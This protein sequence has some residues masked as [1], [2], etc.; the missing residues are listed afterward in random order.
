MAIKI[1]ELRNKQGPLTEE[2]RAAAYQQAVADK[3]T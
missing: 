1:S 3:V 2:E